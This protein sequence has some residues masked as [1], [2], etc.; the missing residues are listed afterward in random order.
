MQPALLFLGWDMQTS[1]LVELLK[2]SMRHINVIVMFRLA[3]IIDRYDLAD[4]SAMTSR[5]RCG[6][7]TRK[8]NPLSA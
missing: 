3:S 8:H 7:L 5:Q 2:D 1:I 4:L 6:M